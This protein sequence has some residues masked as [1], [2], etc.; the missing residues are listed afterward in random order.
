MA[1]NKKGIL[2]VS[3]EWCKHLKPFGKR[4]FWGKERSLTKKDI[5]NRV[6]EGD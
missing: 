5:N 6:K 3:K 1:S 2:T 4:I